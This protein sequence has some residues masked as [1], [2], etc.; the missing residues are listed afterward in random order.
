LKKSKKENGNFL[1]ENA[2]CIKEN[3]SCKLEFKKARYKRE[4]SNTKAKCTHTNG[5]C[6]LTNGK[7]ETRLNFHACGFFTSVAIEVNTN[8]R[9]HVKQTAISRPGDHFDLLPAGSI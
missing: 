2:K 4:M 6:I 1:E 8:L 7:D 9:T 3:A 5:K